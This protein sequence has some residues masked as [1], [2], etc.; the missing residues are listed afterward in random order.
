MPYHSIH[1]DAHVVWLSPAPSS[2]NHI[3]AQIFECLRE[4]SGTQ[5]TIQEFNLEQ[6]HIAVERFYEILELNIQ[7]IK[8]ELIG[9][10][11]YERIHN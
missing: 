10:L 4:I 8:D 5:L 7:N 6:I 11:K 9:A 1:M 3:F 2:I